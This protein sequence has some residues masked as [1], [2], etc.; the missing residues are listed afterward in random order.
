[1]L[2]LGSRLGEA[3]CNWDAELL[4][5]RE[6]V[7]VDLDPRCFGASFDFPTYGVQAEVL[8]FLRGLLTALESRGSSLPLARRA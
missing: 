2:V 1:L 6:L 8:L 4:P 5:E 3:S 7:H